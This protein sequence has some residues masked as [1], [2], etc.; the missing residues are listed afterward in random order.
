MSDVVVDG[1]RAGRALL[2]NHD[3]W[4]DA[5]ALDVQSLHL[6]PLGRPC[7]HQE[8]VHGWF[9]RR[10]GR[11]QALFRWD[12]RLK[13][14]CGREVWDVDESRVRR[15]AVGPLRSLTFASKAGEVG[16]CRWLDWELARRRFIP[17]F[18]DVARDEDDS[19]DF[20]WSRF[21][22]A[23]LSTDRRDRIGRLID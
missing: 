6:K 14:L 23:V 11:V 12:D 1:V 16:T 9:V 15:H 18:V 22:E 21:V 19:E 7:A 4:A 8:H 3:R 10:Q 20:D 17:K 2:I 13:Y 5:R